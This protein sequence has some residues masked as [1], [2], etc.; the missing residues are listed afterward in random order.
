MPTNPIGSEKTAASMRNWHVPAWIGVVVGSKEMKIEA[1]I[2]YAEIS[3]PK[4][5]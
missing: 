4:S 1:L 5:G 3:D 2:T